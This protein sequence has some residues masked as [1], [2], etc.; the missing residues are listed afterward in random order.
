MPGWSANSNGVAGPLFRDELRLARTQTQLTQDELATRI[1]F[2]A[3]LVAAVE[4]GRRVP[5]PEFAAK[6]DEVLGSGGLLSRLQPLVAQEAAPRWFHEWPVI[7]REALLLRCWEPLVI[8]GL[9]QTEDYARELLSLWPGV[10]EDELGQRLSERMERQEILDRERPPELIAI[11]DE[12]ALRYEVGGSRIM[13][14]Q[15]ERLLKLGQRRGI[16]IQVVPAAS[17]ASPGNAGP[18]MVASFGNGPDV[19]NVDNAL[20]SQLVERPEDVFKLTV[21]F[22]KIRSGALPCRASAE[23]IEEVMAQWS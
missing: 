2:S 22:D 13:R 3:S 18:L 12:R 11:I 6:C 4:T 19:A 23:L 7:E 21:L 1:C 9:L 8:S 10:T 14:E 17:G 16:S 20:A 15:M 5:S